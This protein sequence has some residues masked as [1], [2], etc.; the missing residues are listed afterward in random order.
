MNK[1]LKQELIKLI[2]YQN[3]E[4]GFTFLECIVAILILSLAL[5]L[6]GQLVLMLKMQNLQQQIKTA[7]VAVSRERLD[8]LRG[9]LGKNINAFPVTGNTPKTDP[10]WDRDV[11]GRTL[12]PQIYICTEPPTIDEDPDKPYQLKVINCPNT[13]SNRAIRYIVVQVLDRGRNNE[14]IYTVQTNLAQLQISK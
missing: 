6:N 14:R 10:S 13:T 9:Q 3:Q 11:F 1:L 4:G 5:A 8:D 2:K 12:F 7:A